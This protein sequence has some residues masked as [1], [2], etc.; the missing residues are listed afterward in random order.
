MALGRQMRQVGSE[1]C[2]KRMKESCGHQES[3]RSNTLGYYGVEPGVVCPAVDSDE[4]WKNGNCDDVVVQIWDGRDMHRMPIQERLA[5][6]IMGGDIV[7]GNVVAGTICPLCIAHW[8][9][10]EALSQRFRKGRFAKRRSRR[11]S[12]VAN[13]GG[14]RNCIEMGGL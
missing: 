14:G 6:G 1:A 2:V 10:Q 4:W 12:N 9:C 11:I 3:G 5:L 8:H 13:R 7:T